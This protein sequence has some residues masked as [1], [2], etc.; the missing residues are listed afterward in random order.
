[1]QMSVQRG[2][3]L[4][5]AAVLA[6]GC[7]STVDT[8]ASRGGS[9]PLAE[10]ELGGAPLQGGELGT[11]GAVP[12]DGT[13]TTTSTGSG[14]AAG[15][16]GSA[17]GQTGGS[18]PGVGGQGATGPGAPGAPVTTGRTAVGTAPGVSA[19]TI[20]FGVVYSTDTGEANSAIGAEQLDQG[21]ARQYYDALVRS[22]NK[23]GGVAGRKL[24]PSYVEKRTTSSETAAARDQAAC[25]RW[26]KDDKVF[27]IFEGVSEILKAC[28]EKAGM[29]NLH[30]GGGSSNSI[31]TTFARYPHYV[32]VSSIAVDRA[33]R[34]T[35]DGLARSDYFG[36]KP[37]VGVV[38]WDDPNYRYAVEKSLVPAVRALGLD[39]KAPA[40]VTVP[41]SMA[42]LS[43]SGASA[44]SAVLRMR[45]EG[46]T[47]M[48]VIDGPAGVFAGTGLTLLWLKSAGSQSYYPRYGFNDNNSPQSGIDAGLWTADDMRGARVVTWGNSDDTSDKGIAPNAKRKECL[49]LMAREGIEIANA[50]ARYAALRACD[51]IWF[52]RS[53]LGSDARSVT[54]GAF[55]DAVGRLGTSYRSPQVFGTRFSSTQRDGIAKVRRMKLDDGCDCFVY[56]SAPYDTP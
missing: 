20:K 51:Y 36:G 12:L 1:M 33:A 43:D 16:S 23:A 32:E 22:V 18:A 55:V 25:E 40:Y 24:A 38:T 44:N 52:L 19:T 39:I 6:A 10:A 42:G 45:S 9:A 3:A 29:L 28:A 53:V 48:L 7:G 50:N 21:D 46:V 35:V 17:S 41:Q 5:A 8:A 49:D 37:V 26:T 15:T 27:V 4:L 2:A 31:A 47:H 13:G 56:T 30:S 14:S 54:R 34:V 11:G